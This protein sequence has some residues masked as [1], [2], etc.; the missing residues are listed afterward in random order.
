VETVIE[1]NRAVVVITGGPHFLRDRGL[2]ESALAR[3][4]NAF[5]YGEEDIAAL[6]VRLL[7]GIA[8]AHAFAQEQTHLLCG[9]G[10]ISK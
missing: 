9:D 8:Q 5:A 6:A 4:Q 7:A 3:P 2:L 1:I 10:A